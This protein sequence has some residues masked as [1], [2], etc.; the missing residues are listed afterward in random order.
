MVIALLC[1]PKVCSMQYNL[2]CFDFKCNSFIMKQ[3]EIL[4]NEVNVLVEEKSLAIL[5]PAREGTE[6]LVL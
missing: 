6:L 1:S 2:T 4:P 5:S 3:R